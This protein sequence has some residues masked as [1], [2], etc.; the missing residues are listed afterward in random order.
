MKKYARC[1]HSSQV[2][3]STMALLLSCAVGCS[4]DA[5]DAAAGGSAGTAGAAAAAGASG[6]AGAGG[7]APSSGGGTGGAQA[8]AGSAGSSSGGSS[9]AG[10]G[11][12]GGSGL[13]GSGGGT[14]STVSLDAGA[15]LGGGAGDLQRCVTATSCLEFR[16]HSANCQIGNEANCASISN[17]TYFVGACPT[18]QFEFAGV[19]ETFCGPTATFLR[20]SP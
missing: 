9:S 6:S 20:I 3:P 8:A 18:E 15:G 13:S 10:S 14:G 11:G 2:V 5:E 1:G 16:G 12:S 4:D 19:E 17:G 7:S